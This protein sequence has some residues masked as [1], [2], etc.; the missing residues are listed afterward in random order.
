MRKYLLAAVGGAAVASPAVARDGSGYVGHRGRYPVPEGSGCRSY[1][2][3]PRVTQTPASR[4]A[5]GTTGF[6]V[7]TAPAAQG[8][9][10][11]ARRLNS[12]KGYDIDAIA[13]YDFGMFRLEGELGYK[14][15]KIEISKSTARF[16]NRL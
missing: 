15:A 9:L 10:A 12:K 4:F 6:L 14:R 1:V 13:G 16:I 7:G 8:A 2:D 5:V 11:A 3:Y